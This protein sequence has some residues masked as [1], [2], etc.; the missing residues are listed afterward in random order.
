MMDLERAREQALKKAM[1]QM[2]KDNLTIGRAAHVFC[3]ELQGLGCQP[4]E[5][6]GLTNCR[7][8][9]SCAGRTIIQA[10][11]EEREKIRRM[12]SIQTQA[13]A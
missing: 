6:G 13:I 5:N 1:D 3:R 9:T 12:Q 11:I 7:I 2:K 8:F 10:R 4:A